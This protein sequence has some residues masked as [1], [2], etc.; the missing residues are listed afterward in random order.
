V[1][2]ESAPARAKTQ[3]FGGAGFTIALQLTGADRR[4]DT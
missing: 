4:R 2:R 3:A 1:L